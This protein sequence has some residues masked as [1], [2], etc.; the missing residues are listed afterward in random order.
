MGA[1]G[2]LL[3]TELLSVPRGVSGKEILPAYG[4]DSRHGRSALSIP[5]LPPNNADA[6]GAILSHCSGTRMNTA[7]RF[8][9]AGADLRLVPMLLPFFCFRC[10]E[11][12]LR[13]VPLL[14][15]S[16]DMLVEL[17]AHHDKLLA[18]LRTAEANPRQV[19]AL[20]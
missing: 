17:L 15:A 11:A 3:G 1:V 7:D 10:V 19:D 6:V 13:A 4:A 2:A 8:A 12:L 18:T 20:R 16:F 5:A 9:T 14:E